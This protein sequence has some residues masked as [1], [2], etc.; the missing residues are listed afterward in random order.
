MQLGSTSS[1]P[2]RHAQ[3]TVAG[4]GF[5][6]GPRRVLDRVSFTLAPG[7]RLGVV[8]PNGTG[9]T[10]LL[11]LLAGELEPSQ[12][13]VRAAPPDARVGLLHQVVEHAPNETVADF[14]GRRSGVADI[15][16]SFDA[17]VVALSEQTGADGEAS[18]ISDEYD[19]A[20]SR[21]LDADAANFD[22]NVERALVG[23]GLDPALRTRACRELSGGQRSRV[24]LAALA[25]STFDV[26]LLDEPTNDLDLAGLELLE[27]LV[28]SSPVAMAIVS[29][30]RAFLAAVS[31]SIL[32][33]TEHDHAAT[34]FNGGYDAWLTERARAAEAHQ[35]AYDEYQSKRADLAGRAQ[36]Q[37]EWS[38]QG[39]AR[40]RTS[41]E[42]D[43][44]I[45]AF[46]TEASE[47]QASKA[48]QTQRALERLERNEAVT[49]PW[50]PWDLHLRFDEADRVGAEAASLAGAV[51]ERGS[52][53]LGPIDVVVGSK[54]RILITGSNGS[55]KTTLIK[56]LLGELP[57][58]SGT[59]RLGSF[60]QPGVLA[61]DR[62]LFSAAPTLLRAFV[63]QV[64]SDDVE[65]RSQLAKLGLAA[66]RLDRPTTS[67][68]MGERTRAAFGLF[69]IVGTNLL[70]VD[71]PTN[72]LDLPAIEA[73]EDALAH[74][75]HALVA[76]SHDR[77]F[78]EAI[79]VAIP[80]NPK[81]GLT[82]ALRTS[83]PVAVEES[84][85]A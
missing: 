30:D 35:R 65:A 71:E 7:D 20:L 1:T 63:D 61:Q 44:F 18:E 32:E 43:K 82:A 42:P 39:V 48:K 41:G 56:A 14:L 22:A 8:G 59:R 34:Q 70:I 46:K 80:K 75:P 13:S 81:A 10:T 77:R 50:K 74:Y 40:V 5:A 51:V 45:R 31:T 73:L 60:V 25:L 58:T 62:P 6:Y 57:L 52:F 28:T 12:G 16:R 9:K 29:H 83:I 2:S 72:H 17:A 53:V 64:G 26:L 23:V 55:G 27:A 67:L 49:A 47:K 36:R 19:R 21:Y 33:L 78:V 69:A 4:L 84:A 85:M 68:S 54:D 3:L 76:V 38:D 37:R 15:V 79:E 24:G 66:D 11:R